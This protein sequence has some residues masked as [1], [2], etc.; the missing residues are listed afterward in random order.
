MRFEGKHRD[1]TVYARNSHNRINVPLSLATKN[2]LRLACFFMSARGFQN[3]VVSG[4]E[5]KLLLSINW[6]H[7]FSTTSWKERNECNSYKLASSKRTPL[8]T[9]IVH[10]IFKFRRF[11]YFHGSRYILRF[12]NMTPPFLSGSFG[13]LSGLTIECMPIWL[14]RIQNGL[15]L[16]Y[17]MY[18]ISIQ[19]TNYCAACIQRHDLRI[20]VLHNFEIRWKGFLYQNFLL[21]TQVDG[22]NMR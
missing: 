19:S 4:P 17:M 22:R 10:F 6:L 11:P 16:T 1:L 12:R 8:W 7:L 20:F 14:R 9:R 2:Q 13:R 5:K 15:E 3:T 18:K 21:L